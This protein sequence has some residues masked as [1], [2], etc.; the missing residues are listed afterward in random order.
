MVR[1]RQIMGPPLRVPVA[2]FFVAR[3]GQQQWGGVPVIQGLMRMAA[4]I[5]AENSDA[6]WNSCPGRG[7]LDSREHWAQQA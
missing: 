4:S 7:Q 2:F 3:H 1:W 6:P 5:A